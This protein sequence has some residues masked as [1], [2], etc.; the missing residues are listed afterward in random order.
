MYGVRNGT[1]LS[2]PASGVNKMLI[3]AWMFPVRCHLCSSSIEGLLLPRYAV[4]DDLF[5]DEAE[6]LLH[7]LQLSPHLLREQRWVLSLTEKPSISLNVFDNGNISAGER[8]LRPCLFITEP[9]VTLRL[10]MSK[11]CVRSVNSLSAVPMVPWRRRS[12][13]SSFLTTWSWASTWEQENR[14][15]RDRVQFCFSK[16]VWESLLGKNHSIHVV[17]LLPHLHRFPETDL[18]F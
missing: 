16:V 13:S 5:S 12:F 3:F 2:A 11:A 7:L 18:S 17:R 4:F 1:F 6:P 8:S 15:C 10:F 9:F 14:C